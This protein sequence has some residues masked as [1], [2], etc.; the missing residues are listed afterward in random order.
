MAI[1]SAADYEQE[2]LLEALQQINEKE[3]EIND[4]YGERY[5][6]C[7]WKNKK[8]LIIR[9]T[10]GNNL[11]AFAQGPEILLYGNAQEGVA[12]T[13]S[14]GRIIVHGRVGDIAGYGMRG[15]ELFIRNDAGYRLGIHMK[16][17]KDKQP[18]IIVGGCAGA[19]A[20][21]YMAGGNIIILG[22]EKKSPLIGTYCGTG[23][24]GGAIYLRGEYPRK[25]I[26]PNVKIEEVDHKEMSK[27]MIFLER[28]SSHFNYPL[29]KILEEPFTRL[30]MKQ[31]RPFAHLYTGFVS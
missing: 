28:F 26:A 15:G 10:A 11:G 5:I 2:Q 4:C 8:R 25:R 18:L 9:G 24:Y 16:A 30:S 21:E 13:I 12:N 1:L 3:I 17:Y 22:L 14:D 23:M 6:A 20:G 31:E 19:F 29:E 27:I 7:G